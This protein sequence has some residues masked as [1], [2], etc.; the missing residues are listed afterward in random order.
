MWLSDARKCNFWRGSNWSNT[1][2]SVGVV[3]DTA[4]VIAVLC[5]EEVLASF[6][7]VNSELFTNQFYKFV[8][9][10]RTKEKV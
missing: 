2:V 7:P 3:F 4:R 9:R 1:Q 5:N 8:L 6:R 10:L